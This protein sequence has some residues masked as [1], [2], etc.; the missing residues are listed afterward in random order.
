MATFEHLSVPSSPVLKQRQHVGVKRCERYCCMTLTYLP[1]LF[2][3][4]LTTWAIWVEV[5]IGFSSKRPVWTGM[6]PLSLPKLQNMPLSG[7]RRV[8]SCISGADTAV[9]LTQAFQPPSLA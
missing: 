9:M 3:Y 2:V 8:P 1:L 7:W 5:S 4:G 6:L